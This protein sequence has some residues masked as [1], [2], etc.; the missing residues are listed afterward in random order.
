MIYGIKRYAEICSF[1]KYK[2]VKRMIEASKRR[3][4]KIENRRIFKTKKKIGHSRLIKS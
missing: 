2:R 1:L 4:Q 3:I